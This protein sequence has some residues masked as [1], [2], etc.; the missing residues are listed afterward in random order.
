VCK[1]SL[2]SMQPVPPKVLCWMRID[3]SSGIFKQWG[4]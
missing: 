2:R 3:C 1:R 4:F